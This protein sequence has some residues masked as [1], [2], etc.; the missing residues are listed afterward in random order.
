M[1]TTNNIPTFVISIASDDDQLEYWG[2]I[3][4]ASFE[5][6]EADIQALANEL[7][8]TLYVCE[9]GTDWTEEVHPEGKWS[10]AI[11]YRDGSQ[12]IGLEN[13][14]EYDSEKQAETAAADTVSAVEQGQDCEPGEYRV[15]LTAPD[16]T[17]TREECS[18]DPAQDVLDD[19]TIV[20]EDEGEYTT[21]KAGITDDGNYFRT[22]Q[23][24]GSRGAHSRQQ[25][26]GRWDT[27]ADGIQE[28]T[29]T[30][31]IDDIIERENVS[32]LDALRFLAEKHPSEC[33][34]DLAEKYASESGRNA[35]ALLDA[36]IK[37]TL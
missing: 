11:E 6:V 12:W 26:D 3:Q 24:G 13:V 17:E 10:V 21:Y 15:T 37:A 36:L 20:L 23:N 7:G 33:A 29:L 16:G 25:G 4:G 27:R 30:E 8:E 22:Y 35:A 1:K 19:A 2:E 18:Y 5:D 28:I 31:M 9:P 34:D 14:G 32:L